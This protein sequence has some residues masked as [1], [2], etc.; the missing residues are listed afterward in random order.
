M[1]IVEFVIVFL[2]EKSFSRYVVEVVK[3]LDRKGVKY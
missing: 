3:F 1:V 2:G